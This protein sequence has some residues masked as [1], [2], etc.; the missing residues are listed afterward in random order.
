MSRLLPSVAASIFDNE[1]LS[2][3]WA[4]KSISTSEGA[5]VDATFTIHIQAS[6]SYTSISALHIASIF[7]SVRLLPILNPMLPESRLRAVCRNFTQGS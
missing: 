5:F 7:L 4:L 1:L 6:H 3:L 2:Q